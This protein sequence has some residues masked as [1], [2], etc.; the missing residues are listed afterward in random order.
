MSFVHSDMTDLNAF[1]TGTIDVVMSSMALHHLPD[2]AAL[3]RTFSEISRVLRT[4]GALY[5]NDFGRLRSLNSVDYFVRR[6]VG[7]SEP[8]LAED[9]R[10]SLLAAF[11]KDD[12]IR[13]A[14]RWLS[15]RVRVHSTIIS[16]LMVV[17]TSGARTAIDVQRPELKRLRAALPS[18]RRA[19]FRQMRTFLRLGGLACPL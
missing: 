1:G 19:D 7:E 9:Y 12:F 11:T 6:A 18:P 13:S 5:I 16:P 14:E 15:D 10:N 3:D 2:A 4:D 8:I 17:V